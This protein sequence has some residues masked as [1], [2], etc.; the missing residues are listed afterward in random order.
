MVRVRVIRRGDRSYILLPEEL[1]SL[2]E[3][4]VFHLRDNYYLLSAPLS[5]KP[6]T[7][8]PTEE[9]V[10][11]KL[12]SIKF[13]NRTPAY[14]EKVF[15]PEE[16]SVLKLL[17]KKKM[18]NVFRGEKYKE[19]VYN[20]KDSAYALVKGKMKKPASA[21]R[22]PSPYNELKTRGFAVIDDKNTAR[23]FAE[24]LN[25]E[26]RKGSVKGVKGFDGKFYIAT[27]SYLKKASLAIAKILKEPMGIEKIA[28]T[29]NLDEN[30]CRAAI[31]FMSENGEIIEKKKGVFAPVEE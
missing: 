23:R 30:G 24:Q 3:I 28:G 16:K 17:E 8:K 21:G 31:L 4:E 2:E 27:S 10:L 6:E 22:R 5:K 1:K 13:G 20:V 29:A 7:P 9:A 12:L 26:M 25:D 14:I 15:T 18:V 19:G 11:L